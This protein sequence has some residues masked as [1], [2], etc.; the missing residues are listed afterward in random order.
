LQQAFGQQ[1][2][3][4]SGQPQYNMQQLAAIAQKNP[5]LAS[6]IQQNQLAQQKVGEARTVASEKRSFESNKPVMEDLRKI[7][8]SL[9]KREVNL[10]R[11]GEVLGSKDLRTVRNFA[12][13]Y[14]GTKG[15]SAEFLSS[16]SANELNSVVKDEFVRDMQNLPGG[17]RLNQFIERNLKSAL[18]SPL[19]S[20][21]NNQMITEAHRFLY[22]VDKNKLAIADKLLDSYEKMGIEPPRSFERDLEKLSKDYTQQRMK[23]LTQTFKDIGEGKVKSLGAQGIE[24]AKERIQGRP[25]ERGNIYIL[26]PNKEIKQVPLREL[27]KWQDLGGTLI[28]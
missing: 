9:P 4:A 24:I 12:A 16:K 22:D 18:Q 1:Q 19:K 17:T 15:F 5:Q 25:P 11:I 2:Q 8:T 14:L 6:L 21:E 10:M 7:R 13:D 23:E 28:K 26:S 20:P 3:Q 27:K